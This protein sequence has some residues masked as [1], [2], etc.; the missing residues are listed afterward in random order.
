MHRHIPDEDLYGLLGIHAHASHSE[1]T[2]AYR[3]LAMTWHPDR[4]GSHDAEER[5][6]RIRSAYEI[7]RD[8]HRR[9][10]YDRS[11]RHHAVRRGHWPHPGAAPQHEPR[12]EQRRAEPEPP[13]AR[14]G[15]L[16]RRIAITLEEQVLGCR[17]KLKVTRTEYC[18]KCD[19]SGRL[20]SERVMCHR[21]R[22]AGRV[23][24]SSLSF[25]FFAA[26]EVECNACGG[27]GSVFPKCPTCDGSGSGASRTGHLRF[28]VPAGVRPD[29]IKRVRGFGRPGR[30][31]QSAGDL[32]IRIGF[33]PHPLFEP[34]FPHLRCEMP[35]S[36]FRILAGG[37]IEVPT[38]E[39][40]VSVALPQDAADG[41]VLRIDGQGLLDG[42][43]EQR[44]SLFVT[45]RVVR[46]QALTA[47]QMALVNELERSFAEHPGQSDALADWARRVK[48]A[49]R[50]R[51]K[52]ARR[53]A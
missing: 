27:K 4:N 21:C 41:A 40:P 20:E 1:I 30:Q 26:G 34:D 52:V 11:A 45:L 14:A 16:S 18:I 15:N 38:L 17:P 3:K 53:E 10:E 37:S 33:A 23:R 48:D 9:A 44:G 50:R 46:P 13:A 51:A 39:A 25:F 35:V 2:R 42:A 6:K 7:L 5:F 24:N 49:K 36:A 28:D 12:A 29:A 31:S 47:A 8:P 32:L 22:G 19:G 43:S